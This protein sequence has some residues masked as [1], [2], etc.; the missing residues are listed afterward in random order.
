MNRGIFRAAWVGI[1]CSLLTGAF[2]AESGTSGNS[3]DVV[4]Q[5]KSLNEL[6]S[7]VKKA[8]QRFRSLYA[9]LNRDVQQQISC[10]DDAA[11]GTRFKKRKCTTRAA[12][13][14][15]AQAAQDYVSTADLNTSTTSTQTG[16]TAATDVAGPADRPA[17]VPERYVAGVSSVDLKNPQDSY[18][19]NLEK[20]M[21]ENPELRQRYEEYVQA[22]AQ[23]DAAENKAG[24]Q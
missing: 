11:T 12:Q 2:A 15:T 4:V 10:K 19:R 18:R 13:N 24:G 9:R 22:R 6:R 14:A 3:Q 1:G 23:L 16:R 17:S 8:D 21:N 20:L 7:N 5:G